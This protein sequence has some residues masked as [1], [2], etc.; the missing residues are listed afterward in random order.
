MADIQ[1]PRGQSNTVRLF[2][3]LNDCRFVKEHDR[4]MILLDSIR[5]FA[6][7]RNQHRIVS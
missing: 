4:R 5:I 3:P 1:R 6:R 2:E 7:E